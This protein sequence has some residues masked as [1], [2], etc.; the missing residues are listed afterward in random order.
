M[1]LRPHAEGTEHRH[2]PQ[3]TRGG[4]MVRSQISWAALTSLH[5]IGPPKFNQ[6]LHYSHQYDQ[7]PKGKTPHP[8]SSNVR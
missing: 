2:R 5:L 6:E 3:D 8:A 4:E 7:H 1:A